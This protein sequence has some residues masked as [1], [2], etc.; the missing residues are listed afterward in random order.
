MQSI[1][2][3]TSDLM[4]M[5]LVFG[6]LVYALFQLVNHTFRQNAFSK[7]WPPISDE[8]FLRR[9]HVGVN[10]EIALRVRRIV[11]RQL[12]VPY[13]QVYPEQSF[14]DDLCS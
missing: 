6:V 9:C 11:S 1:A 10:P 3:S 5:L 14:V 13:E 4:S 2:F 8:E 7:E 12:G